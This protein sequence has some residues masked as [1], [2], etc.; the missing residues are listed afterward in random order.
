MAFGR[1]FL[2]AMGI[3]SDKI[4]QII[5]AHIEVTD[6]L[7]ADRDK[8]KEAAEKLPGVQK[9]LEDVTKERDD[10]KNKPD[11]GYKEKYD[12]EHKAFEDY[13]NGIK[14]KELKAAKESAVRKYYEGKGIKDKSLDIAMRGSSA[15]IEALELD[16]T[17][18]IKDTKALDDLVAGT[19]AGLVTT[20]RTEPANTSTPP[21]GG[22]QS[23]AGV[24]RA[25]QLYSEHYKSLYGAKGDK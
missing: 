23:G 20:Q 22:T 19:F 11:D 16:D 6:G 8:Y 21:T 3:E 17:G 9:E 10:L 13:K 7:K 25:A 5:E 12:K 15:E 18:T 14:A 24:S 1:K 2:A 4:E